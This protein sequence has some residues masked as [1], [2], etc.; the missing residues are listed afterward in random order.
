MRNLLSSSPTNINYTNYN[1]NNNNNNN[2]ND[3]I[4]T[5]NTNSRWSLDQN[6]IVDNKSLTS[7]SLELASPRE[8][9]SLDSLPREKEILKNAAAVNKMP[10]IWKTCKWDLFLN[11]KTKK[12]LN[13][14]KL[15]LWVINKNTGKQF[16]YVSALNTYWESGRMSYRVD[17]E[18]WKNRSHW[19][20][21]RSHYHSIKHLYDD[22]RS[23]KLTSPN[24]GS[25]T[26][27]AVFVYCDQGIWVIDTVRDGE[28]YTFVLNGDLTKQ[29][30]DANIIATVAIGG[31]QKRMLS[32]EE[33]GL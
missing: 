16:S 21:V 8:K 3:L 6:G 13:D 28:I 14:L 24:K 33:S 17:P 2:T 26:E 10:A 25:P 30:T 15:K 29:Q 7:S 12:G 23:S 27:V 5:N 22:I 32:L 11:G 18:E 4:T 9:E 31:N 19:I 1:N 20:T